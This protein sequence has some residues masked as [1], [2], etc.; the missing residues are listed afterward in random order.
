MLGWL[1]VG[2]VCGSRRVG[3]MAE[4]KAGED[5]CGGFLSGGERAMWVAG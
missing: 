4:G 3:G 5:A 1:P 2:P